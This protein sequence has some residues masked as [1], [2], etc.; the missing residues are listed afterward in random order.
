MAMQVL[1]IDDDPLEAEVLVCR[2]ERDGYSV[3]TANTGAEGLRI[4]EEDRVQFLILDLDMPEMDGLEVLR[5]VRTSQ[6]YPPITVLMLS[7]SLETERKVQALEIGADDFL[8]KPVEYQ[9]LRAKL[10][11]FGRQRPGIEQL[12]PGQQFLQYEL[13]S[14][15]GVGGM[16]KVFQAYDTRLRRA[17]AL[18]ILLEQSVTSLQRF[19]REARAISQVSHAGLPT[20]YEVGDSPFPFLSMEFVA[21]EVLAERIWPV[22]EA[23]AMVADAAET[24][25]VV[26]QHGILHRDIKPANLMRTPG[27]KIKVLD[28]GLAK[29][30]QVDD[31]LTL[32]GDVLGTP[33]Y[34]SPESFDGS[35]GPVDFQSDVYSL[36]VTLYH[37]LTGRLPFSASK[38]GN[39]LQQVLFKEPESLGPDFPDRLQE[40]CS[41][42]FAR[43]KSER[44]KS[45]GELAVALRALN[46][47]S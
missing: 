2:L 1:I 43:N 9:F 3:R 41:R 46:S 20:I 30:V 27:G 38:L 23:V 17:V 8:S 34:M 25:E 45:A 5:R 19:L 14:I 15:L 36:T 32:N 29:M 28:F 26:H 4:L 13:T 33:H 44:Y 22:R 24:V 47:Q 35:R 18:K 11:Q 37:L 21:G 31:H 40:I 6:V 39:L 16:G 7:A 10:K 42:G 12:A